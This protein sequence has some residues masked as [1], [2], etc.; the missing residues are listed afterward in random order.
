MHINLKSLC[1]IVYTLQ[2]APDDIAAWAKMLLYDIIGIDPD[3]V[4]IIAKHTKMND[5]DTFGGRGIRDGDELYFVMATRYGHSIEQ[6]MGIEPLGQERL[7]FL[8][9][10]Y[11]ATPIVKYFGNGMPT[12]YISRDGSEYD[13]S[14]L[15]RLE[16][17]VE[18]KHI[19]DHV[20]YPE[21]FV[22][23]GSSLNQISQRYSNGI[24]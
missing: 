18:V 20:R 12:Q 4:S 8:L 5:L 22:D 15:K 21:N 2:V 19:D 6:R 13:T 24:H 11:L 3:V 1:G 10:I 16:H 23:E 9:Q 7:R 14:R 17:L